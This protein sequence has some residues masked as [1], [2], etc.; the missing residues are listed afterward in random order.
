LTD[1]AYEPATEL[2]DGDDLHLVVMASDAKNLGITR[3]AAR[4]NHAAGSAGHEVLVE[5]AN[6][7]PEPVQSELTVQLETGGREQ[8]PNDMKHSQIL[9]IPADSRTTCVVSLGA[10]N[11]GLIVAELDC[12]DDFVADNR[13]QL[14]VPRV[15]PQPLVIA[16]EDSPVL[17]ALSELRDFAV[18]RAG[19]APDDLPA[20]AVT[21]F[22]G[23]V[24]GQLPP[25]PTL[26]V[27]PDRKCDLWELDEG[28]ADATQVV[29]PVSHVSDSPLLAGV[30]LSRVVFEE[31]IPL[32]IAGEVEPLVIDA[33]GRPLYL[34]ARR[35]QGLG[36]VLVLATRLTR[37]NSDLT[38]RRDFPILLASAVRWLS[39]TGEAVRQT[40]ST[41]QLVR[42]PPSS[43]PRNLLSPDNRRADVPAGQERIGPLAR[44]GLWTVAP[45]DG[46]GDE[47][48]P[49]GR[50][51]ASAASNDV[52]PAW[53]IAVS[54]VDATESDVRP[55]L[56]PTGLPD[57]LLGDGPAMPLWTCLAAVAVLVTL[58]EWYLYHRR[59]LI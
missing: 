1:A 54:L 6:F 53:A 28:G 15:N 14:L 8:S 24:P 27:E 9:Q 40:T 36:P 7:G 26:I 33:A 21:V 32:Q 57:E 17:A 44:G 30:D 50:A 49:E 5:I 37:N 39:G 29:L 11:A 18:D 38:M 3:L 22:H 52:A 41:S 55:R 59:I 56:P 2:A 13:A 25:G 58:I 45:G 10:V 20:G 34:L 23:R 48:A 46:R 47:P 42:L 16:S 35:S 31:A 19:T 4:P 51:T 43:A 12:Q